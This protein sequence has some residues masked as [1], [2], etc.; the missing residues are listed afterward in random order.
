MTTP[1][2]YIEKPMLVD[3]NFILTFWNW[4]KA[5]NHIM[6]KYIIMINWLEAKLIKKIKKFHS[7]TCLHGFCSEE[8]LEKHI[9]AKEG[10]SPRL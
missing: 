5:T 9:L 8:L 4:R 6:F 3:Q 7:H 2:Y 1:V 10:V